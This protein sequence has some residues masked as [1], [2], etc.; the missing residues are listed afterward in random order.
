MKI[1][2]NIQQALEFGFCRTDSANHN[3]VLISQTIHIRTH[4]FIRSISTYFDNKVVQRLVVKIIVVDIQQ[5]NLRVRVE[6]VCD[7]NIHYSSLHEPVKLFLKFL[8]HGNIKRN[9]CIRVQELFVKTM[10]TYI[11]NESN[12]INY[13]SFMMSKYACKLSCGSYFLNT[14]SIQ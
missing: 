7:V 2:K 8:L 6:M 1:W 11:L 10:I 4:V 9:L 13:E 5:I 3:S 12:F 14:Y